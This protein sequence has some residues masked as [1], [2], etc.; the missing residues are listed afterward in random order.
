MESPPLA[1]FLRALGKVQHHLHTIVIGLSAVER[2]IATKP[3][4]LD[5]TWK[6]NDPTGSAREARRFLLRAS[7]I[8]A[9][10]E[11]NAYSASVLRY[12]SPDNELPGGRADRIRT[13]DGFEQVEPRYL[14]VAPLIVS[15]WRNRIVHRVSRA[16]LTTAEKELLLEQKEAVHDAFKGIDVARL[17]QDYENDTPTLK[18]VTVLLAMSIHFVRQIDGRFPTPNDSEQVRRWLDAENLLTEVLRL[19]KQAANGGNPDPRKRVNQYLL[20]HAPV[21]AEA[22]RTWGAGAIDARADQSS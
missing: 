11:L 16:T 19:E 15:H 2:G 8:F 13:L 7:L 5:I 18:D 6:A 21:L 4:D 1:R 17:L 12:Q 14:R 10:E 3:D 20:T 22:Y 9:A